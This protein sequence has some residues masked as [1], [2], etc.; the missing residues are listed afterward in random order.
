[1]VCISHLELH[2]APSTAQ[3]EGTPAVHGGLV[4]LTM[5]CTFALCLVNAFPHYPSESGYLQFTENTYSKM[6]KPRQGSRP[7]ENSGYFK[8]SSPIG[9]DKETGFF[10]YN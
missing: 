4:S 1:M 2:I 6:M 10:L 5:N 3:Y 9:W 7:N 8:T